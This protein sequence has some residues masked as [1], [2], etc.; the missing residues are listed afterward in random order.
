MGFDLSFLAMFANRP[1]A[2][3]AVSDRAERKRS[4]GSVPEMSPMR[5]V[6]KS[7]A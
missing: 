7:V 2:S 3:P 6:A 5:V 4:Q 1:V